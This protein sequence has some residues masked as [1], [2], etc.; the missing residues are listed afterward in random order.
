MMMPGREYQAQPSRFG[1]NGKEN[2]NEVKGF[3]NQQDYGMRIYDVRIGKFLSVDPLATQYP[4]FSPYQFAG[5]GP[6][7]NIDLDGEEPKPS[8]NG[9]QEGQST[10]TSEN[11]SYSMGMAGAGHT[12]FY[13][14]STKWFWHAGGLG[15]GRKIDERNST[16]EIISQTEI[17]Q[18]RDNW[19]RKLATQNC[20]LQYLVAR[21]V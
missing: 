21:K 19:R 15:T 6:I 14:A 8:I 16:G 13:T 4:W 3:G 17:L 10:T 7:A 1:F 20:L 5:N 18:L 12:A 2:D 9:T 11:R